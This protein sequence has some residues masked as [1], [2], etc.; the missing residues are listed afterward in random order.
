MRRPRRMATWWRVA[1]AAV[2]AVLLGVDGGPGAAA[3]APPSESPRPQAVRAH[4]VGGEGRVDT[5]AR[6]AEQAFTAR[7]TD[8]AVL[9]NAGDFPDALAASAVAGMHRAPLL[10]TGAG[11]L[12][13]RTRSA[14]TAL[15][16]QRIVIVGGARAVGGDVEAQLA[17]RYAVR[18][19]SG[20][21][22]YATAAAVAGHVARQEGLP[23]RGDAATVLVASGET[24]ADA[25]V[26]SP[27]AYAGRYPLLLTGRGQLPAAAARVLQRN[28][29]DRAIVLGGPAAIAAPVLDDL[30]QRG[31][32]TERVAGTTRAATAAA[33]ARVLTQRFGF[34]P[35]RSVLA[36]GDTFPDAVAAGPLAGQ[37]RSPVL[38][39]AG[40]PQLGAAT[41]QWI[42]R[43]CRAIRGLTAVGGPG[44]VTSSTLRAAAATADGCHPV[45]RTITYETGTRGGVDADLAAFRRRVAATLG[46][47]RGW[48]LGGDV[49]FRRVSDGGDLRLWLAAPAVV[50]GA[51]PGCGPRWSCRVGDDVY[52]NA[53]RWREATASYRDAGRPLSDY[54]AYVV[55]HEVGHWLGLGHRQCPNPGQPAPVMLQQSI[56]LDGCTANPWPLPD[57]RTRVRQRQLP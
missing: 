18:R 43:Q 21:D 33:F 37:R 14:L 53:R 7:R 39:T 52:L 10:L 23:A 13:P 29:V 27:L 22:R 11:R 42:A 19:L 12:P 6:I 41:Q 34:R 3:A 54:R 25:L 44:A 40:P 8:T 45:Q 57:E 51:H 1:I 55:N 56:S 20:E 32:A 31:I 2:M 9:V 38:L 16:I 17:E 48:S 28:D 5:A 30:R 50:A 46:D 24:F 36:R 49:A 15:D 26:A 47:A 4:R 35:E